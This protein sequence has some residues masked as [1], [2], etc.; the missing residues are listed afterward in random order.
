MGVHGHIENPPGDENSPMRPGDIYQETKLEVWWSHG[1]G[2][3]LYLYPYLYP[4]T[5]P[6]IYPYTYPLTYSYL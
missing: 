3:D 2:H 4:Y 6:Y 5:C 1:R